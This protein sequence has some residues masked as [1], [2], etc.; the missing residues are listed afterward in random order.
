MIGMGT[1][2]HLLPVSAAALREVDILGVFRYA[3]TY[4]EGIEMVSHDTNQA[5]DLTKLITHHVKGLQN[6]KRLSR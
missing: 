3:N 5:L 2:M 4:P 6:A 1:P